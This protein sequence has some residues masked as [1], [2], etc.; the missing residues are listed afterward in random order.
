MSRGRGSLRTIRLRTQKKVSNNKTGG[1]AA[2]TGSVTKEGHMTS[3]Q[4]RIQTKFLQS[5]PGGTRAPPM[6]LSA[7]EAGGSCPVYPSRVGVVGDET[8]SPRIE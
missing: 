4:I 2:N 1:W 6:G 3:T 7:I 8:V 5:L